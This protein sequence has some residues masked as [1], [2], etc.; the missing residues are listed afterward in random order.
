MDKDEQAKRLR[1]MI[2]L[3]RDEGLSTVKIARRFSLTRQAVHGRLKRAGVHIRSFGQRQRTIES[4]TLMRLYV[5]EQLPIYKIAQTLNADFRTVVR[6]LER[7][8]IS[9]RPR[10]YERR[11]PTELDNLKV[12]ES[13]LVS[14]KSERIPY[15]NYYLAA[16]VR[17]IKVS[18]RRVESGRVRVTRIE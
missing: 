9:R 6:Q 15:V 17:G 8:S 5:G 2:R 12:G 1:E 4:E 16:Q 18:V 3:Y 10:N 7:H 14:Y 11:K 13:A